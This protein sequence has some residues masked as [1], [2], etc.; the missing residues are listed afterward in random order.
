VNDRRR[1][2]LSRERASFVVLLLLLLLLLLLCVGDREMTLCI[3]PLSRLQKCMPVN[4]VSGQPSP[5][6]R[7][8]LQR[9]GVRR[10]HRSNSNL[11]RRTAKIAGY[12]AAV[13]RGRMKTL[14]KKEENKDGLGGAN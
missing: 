8:G 6:G 13:T 9:R 14:W 3:D 2:R 7:H 10:D 12:R 4:P 5:Y 11:Q 1:R